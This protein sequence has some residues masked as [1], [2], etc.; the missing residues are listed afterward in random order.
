MA[1]AKHKQRDRDGTRFLALPL[2]VLESPCFVRLS[3]HAVRLLLDIAMQLND[4]NSGPNNG[5]LIASTRYLSTRGWK[6][7]DM[8]VKARR[9]LEAAGL[10]IETRKGA[11]PNRAAWYAVTWKPLAWTPEMDFPRDPGA[12]PRG[13]YLR[14]QS[15]SDS[16]ACTDGPG[17]NA[18]VI[19]PHGIEG[20]SIVPPHGIDTRPPIPP[21]GTIRPHFH[22]LSIPPHG[23]Y[24]DLPSPTG[25]DG[26][27]Q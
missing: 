21:H 5:R 7:H 12:F 4:G 18:N 14:T 27:R 2:V 16:N 25:K 24:L 26:G 22:P 8:A 11:R 6:S 19:P 10:L 20:P 15:E 1:R 3:P 13:A 17:K 9:E 23:N